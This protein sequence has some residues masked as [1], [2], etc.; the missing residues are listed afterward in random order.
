MKKLLIGFAAIC[1]PIFIFI[2]LLIAVIIPGVGDADAST[3]PQFSLAGGAYEASEL[4]EQEFGSQ[5]TDGGV[6][7]IPVYKQGASFCPNL[8]WTFLASIGKQESNHGTFGGSVIDPVT[9]DASQR[10]EGIDEDGVAEGLGPMQI[11]QSNWNVHGTDADGR[12]GADID[13]FYDAA[14]TAAVFLCNE[15]PGIGSGS[16]DELRAA[17][18]YY[19]AGNQPG[20]GDGYAEEVM[21]RAATYGQRVNTFSGQ[22]GACEAGI[23]D[24]SSPAGD[25]IQICTDSVEN[26]KALLAAAEVDG[27]ILGSVSSYRSSEQQASLRRQNCSVQFAN[28]DETQEDILLYAREST[29]KVSCNPDTAPVGQSNHES[30]RA[31]DFRVPGFQKFVNSPGFPWMQQNAGRFGFINYAPEPWHWSTDGN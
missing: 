16:N 11:L 5:R 31:I 19:F 23:S 13:N 26:I 6:N 21:N 24:I 9:L 4:A 2:I 18:A 20:L 25:N 10:I 29:G 3:D 28:A 7:L 12:N 30:G 27:I 1:S 17:A 15:G 8:P 22:G 14:A